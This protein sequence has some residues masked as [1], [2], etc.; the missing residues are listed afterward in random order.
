MPRYA[1][2]LTLRVLRDVGRGGRYTSLYNFFEEIDMRHNQDA[3]GVVMI[4]SQSV[5]LAATAEGVIDTIGGNDLSVNWDLGS[6]AS[7]LNKASTMK[8]QESDTDEA[9]AYV[10]IPEAVGDGPEGFTIPDANTTRAQFMRLNLDLNGRKRFIK[11]LYTPTGAAQQV[12][13][14]GVLYRPAVGS[15]I[16]ARNDLTVDI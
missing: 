11:A 15:E 14:T 12:S 5:G 4:E 6:Q 3:G 9:T 1:F 13:V 7:T 16:R 10:D 2:A 8:L